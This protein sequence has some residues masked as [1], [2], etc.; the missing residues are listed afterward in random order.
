[1]RNLTM[2]CLV[3]LLALTLLVSGT[4]CAADPLGEAEPETVHAGGLLF[5]PD[6]S[7]YFADVAANYNW[8]FHEIDYLANTNVVAGTGRFIFQPGQVADPRRLYPDALSCVRYGEVCG[9]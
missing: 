4:A 5:I 6:H 1:M 7:V 2:R 9:G 3:L 8:A